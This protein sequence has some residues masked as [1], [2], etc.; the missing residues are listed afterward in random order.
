ML[1]S[2]LRSTNQFASRAANWSINLATML[3]CSISALRADSFHRSS[4]ARCCSSALVSNSA[5]TRATIPACS[6]SACA[7]LSRILEICDSCL[8]S[9]SEI[10]FASNF[11]KSIFEFKLVSLSIVSSSDN[12]LLSD[13]TAAKET[14]SCAHSSFASC[15]CFDSAVT[16]ADR[17]GE[18][19][20]VG[21]IVS[22]VLDVTVVNRLFCCP[23]PRP[24]KC[25]HSSFIMH[26]VSLHNLSLSINRAFFCIVAL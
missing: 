24:R 1:S 9:R 12:P 25:S 21:S 10:V 17:W 14:L 22:G 23:N 11:A 3:A 18:E 20:V 8:D 13:S 26:N 2:E 16:S 6:I 4:T 5:R 15:N 19:S 7:A